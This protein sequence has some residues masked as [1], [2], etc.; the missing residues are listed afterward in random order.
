M[1]N[2]L[3]ALLLFRA[4][5]TGLL[6]LLLSV[7]SPA[8]PFT[9]GDITVYRVGDGTSSLINRGNPVF[10]DEFTPDGTLI[11]SVALPTTGSGSNNQLI[12]SGTAISE[13]LLTRSANGQYLLLTGYARNLGG[14]NSL[15]GTAATAVPRTVARVKFDGSIDTTTALTDFASTNNPRSAASTDGL[16]IWVAG[17]AGGVRY[18]RYSTFGST[19]S[20]QLSR[21][22]LNLEQVAIFDGQLYV[23]GQKNGITVA[24]VGTNQP[25]TSGQSITNL[26]GL[27]SS[28]H[29]YAFFFADLADGTVLYAA[30]DTSNGGEILKYSLIGGT[31]I[32]NGSINAAGVRGLTGVIDGS[33]VTLYA[34]TGDDTATGGGTLYSFDDPTGYAGTVSGTASALV[35][36]DAS[37]NKAFR[38]VALAPVNPNAPTRTPNAT[39]TP[40]RSPSVTTTPTLLVT[41]TST[42]TA[43]PHASAAPTEALT[44]VATPTHTPIV[45]ETPSISPSP[46]ASP[47]MMPFTPGNLAVY[48]VGDGVSGLANSGNAVFIDEYTPNGDL[49]QSIALPVDG[50]GA[51]HPLIAS[52]TASSEGMLTRSADGH[53]LVVTG[54]GVA[55]GG[56]ASLSSS[57]AATVPRTVGLVAADGSIDTS[58]ALTDFS[59][60]NNPRAAATTDGSGVWVGGAAGGVRY[61]PLGGTTSLQLSADSTN[62]RAVDIVAGQL[63]MS[64]QKGS[65]RVATVGTGTPTAAGQSI[66][67]LPGFPTTGAPDAFFFADL[68]GSPGIDTLYVA[69]DGAGQVQKY[70]LVSGTWTASGTISAASVHGVTGSVSPTVPVTVTLYATG[71]SGA[72]G[73]LYTFA[74]TAGYNANIS[75]S[76]TTIA[77]APASEAFRGVALVPVSGAASTTPTQTLAPGG[78][79]VIPSATVDTPT[80]T[81]TIAATPSW[82]ATH[83]AIPTPIPSPFTAG[84]VVIYRVGDGVTMLASGVGS[85]VFLDEYSPSGTLV[86]SVGLPTT[87]GGSNQPLIATGTA[88]T[89]GQLTR[90]ADRQYLLLTG[91]GAAIGTAGLTMSVSTSVPRVVGRVDH[92]GAIDTSTALTDFSS[93]DKPRGA[94]STDGTS[95]WVTGGGKATSGT[96][97]VHYTTLG[98]SSSTQI[99]STFGDYRMVNVFDNQL[100]VSSQNSA[101]TFVGTVGTGTPVT[102]GQTTTPL[103]GF[104]DDGNKPEG[105]FFADLDGSPGLD[106]LYIAD[107]VAGLQKWS[108]VS[109]Q[110]GLTDTIAPADV[111]YGVTGVVNG[112]TVVLYVTGSSSTNNAGTLYTLADNGGYNA[113]IDGTLTTLAT[114]AANEAF[115]GVALA[116][117][118]SL[119]TTPTA[120]PEQNPSPTPI[121]CAGDCDRSGDVTSGDLVLMVHVALGTVAFAECMPGDRDGSGDITVDEILAAVNNALNQCHA[122]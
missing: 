77:T 32:D 119:S 63:Y 118:G 43:T 24:T 107:E 8:A 111:L 87:S 109:G 47:R 36:L 114:A 42:A 94:A 73:T 31:W 92:T 105:F 61:A 1:H 106:T 45:D 65:I 6:V 72:D 120:T 46:D 11:Q 83:T 66:T 98:S 14:G 99:S 115:R 5:P 30:D 100:Y 2:R 3:L 12:A 56:T 37:S 67:S 93:G 101:A 55:L 70:S 26:P 40:T 13:G 17:G 9:P 88:G 122:E 41:S 29:L 89:E 48:R 50:N 51:N 84:D 64:S 25:T 27:A 57:S 75:G 95:I 96:D 80:R 7:A 10:L 121:G 91:Y 102:D 20:T 39:S 81:P 38:G 74:D 85:P 90:S 15:S 69:D 52:G 59:D 97:G 110:W 58:T 34:T 78:T 68:D 82:T 76:A 104:V 112:P 108:L 33:T 4:L 53:Y 49:V 62:I 60:S 79:T 103:P 86:Q 21:D 18:T 44:A 16:D 23:S 28:T 54:Y 117:V 113:V 71:T 22:S 35:T 19:S 116:P